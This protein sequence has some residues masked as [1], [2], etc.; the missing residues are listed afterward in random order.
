MEN[1]VFLQEARTDSKPSSSY[2]SPIRKTELALIF[3]HRHKKEWLVIVRSLT[4]VRIDYEDEDHCL[5]R[6]AF[7]NIPACVV[8]ENP[9]NR[10]NFLITYVANVQLRLISIKLELYGNKGIK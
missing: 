5:I 3:N 6:R 8:N 10:K 7:P 9:S 4:H 2:E 1:S